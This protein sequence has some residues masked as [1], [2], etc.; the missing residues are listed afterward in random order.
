MAFE[1]PIMGLVI[2]LQVNPFYA[3]EL[4]KVLVQ[5]LN[6]NNLEKFFTSF[7]EKVQRTCR[8][9][10]PAEMEV[11]ATNRMGDLEGL[12]LGGFISPLATFNYNRDM[13]AEEMIKMDQVQDR[14]QEE[15]KDDFGL[16]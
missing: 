15:N 9:V 8:I 16:Q 5:C 6:D 13:D 3:E 2:D 10:L 4:I 12:N 1:D 14:P 7:H 11:E